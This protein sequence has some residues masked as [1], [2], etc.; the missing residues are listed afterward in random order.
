MQAGIRR[1]LITRVYTLHNNVLSTEN[2]TPE[3][4]SQQMAE[5]KKSG[6]DIK[7]LAK[8]LVIVGFGARKWS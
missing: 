1:L 5:N 8:M 4:I 3:K 6:D 2:T 7:S